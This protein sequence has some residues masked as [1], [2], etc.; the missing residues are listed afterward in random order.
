[1]KQREKDDP[2]CFITIR[3]HLVRKYGGCWEFNE[4]IGYIQ[5]HFLGDQI[6]GEYFTVDAKKVV[7]TRKKTLEYKTHKLAAEVDIESP[8]GTPEI[9]TAIRR[10]IEGCK[11]E[12]P[13]R[14]IDTEN[15]DTLAPHVDWAA[16]W[17]EGLRA[18]AT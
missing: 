9:L 2:R 14:L 18:H 3:D 8:H 4:I 12:L 16:L 13:Y 17:R 7:R 11:A 1:M 10:Y 15:F 6:R 5:L